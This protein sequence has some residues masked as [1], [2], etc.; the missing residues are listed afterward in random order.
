MRHLKPFSFLSYLL[1]VS[2]TSWTFL[3]CG[4]D[5]IVP[6]QAV[7]ASFVSDLT[8]NCPTPCQVCFTNNSANATSYLWDFGNGQ[9]STEQ[10]PCVTYTARGNY[11]VN[12]T[13]FRGSE[14]HTTL[15]ILAVGDNVL[16]YKRTFSST[17]SGFVEKLA[18]QNGYTHV[19][20]TVDGVKKMVR[21][22]ENNEFYRDF[23]ANLD[24]VEDIVSS[25]DGG[26]F[27]VGTSNN[28]PGIAKFTSE[29]DLVYQRRYP[30][31]RSAGANSIVRKSTGQFTG[32]VVCG[33]LEDNW[34]DNQGLL[35][36]ADDDGYI[37]HTDPVDWSL[38]VKRIFRNNDNGSNAY[39]AFGIWRDP[40]QQKLDIR[41]FT[42]N[43]QGVD[44]L[45][46]NLYLGLANG[47]DDG[48]SDAIPYNNNNA[49]AAVG[50]MAGRPLFFTVNWQNQNFSQLLIVQNFPSGVSRLSGVCELSDGSGFAVCSNELTSE[51]FW[52]YLAK[53]AH[54]GTVL[55][56]KRLGTRAIFGDIVATP[57]GGMLVG[58]METCGNLS[59]NYPVLFKLDTNGDFE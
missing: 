16:R 2:V 18:F 32:Y 19:L 22:N 34:S 54:N 17:N 4:G 39:M 24:R 7:M 28:A 1:L 50:E 44:Y 41:V 46:A 29:L 58:G 25:E 49:Y 33:Q 52:I 9:T 31:S 27:F 57:D 38:G 20:M 47:R 26:F 56:Q 11:N 8:G 36:N 13:A 5:P 30:Q 53:I 55:W 23:T 14:T 3:A 45:P 48:L 59:C 43:E 35:I 42:V 10:H 15:Q 6:N 51:G 12:L 21:F 40:L 37:Y